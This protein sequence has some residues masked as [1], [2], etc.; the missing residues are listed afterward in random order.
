MKKLI[1][2]FLAAIMLVP[3][4]MAATLGEFPGFLATKTDTTSRANAYVIVGRSAAAS[5]V[6][7]G[8]DLAVRIAEM[9]YDVKQVP[10]GV[11]IGC[12]YGSC[13][14]AEVALNDGLLNDTMG[15]ELTTAIGLGPK[16]ITYGG[17]EYLVTEKVGVPAVSVNALGKDYN[18]TIVMQLADG[19]LYYEI[20]LPDINRTLYT[21]N[22]KNPLKVQI[23]GKLFQITGAEADKFT[24]LTGV[25]GD[26]DSV[27]PKCVVYGDYS[28]CV[29]DGNGAEGWAY[30]VVKDAAGN[31]IDSAWP[32]VG[33][34]VEFTLGGQTIKAKLI[35][36]R[37]SPT[38][39]VI[40]ATLVVGPE[41]DEVYEDGEPFPGSELWVFDITTTGDCLTSIKVEYKP[42]LSED[43]TAKYVTLGKKI[44]AP[45]D[46]FEFGLQD[47]LVKTYTK[48][49]FSAGTATIYEDETATKPLF[50]NKPAIIIEATD[51]VF[52]NQNAKKAYIAYN[53]SLYVIG[54][55]NEILGRII[56]TDMEADPADLDNIEGK[57]DTHEFV[58]D[59]QNVSSTFAGLVL[60]DGGHESIA[61]NYTFTSSAVILGASTSPEAGDV[62]EWDGTTGVGDYEGPDL[63]SSYGSVLKSNIKAN[64]GAQK[65]VVELPA[66]QQKAFVYMGKIG[67][68]V[69]TGGTYKEMVPI[70]TPVTRFADEITA[71]DKTST[72]AFVLVGGPCVNEL[73]A[74]LAADGKLKDSTGY[75]I[76]SCEAWPGRDFAL[77]QLIEDA[78][79]TTGK[80]VLVV[81]GT[82]AQDTLLAAQYLQA[83]KLEGST[84]KAVEVTGT[85]VA[86]ATATPI[87]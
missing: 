33:E 5:D 24:A 36:V 21:N 46:Y 29:P 63:T 4:A 84:A 51:Y 34:T 48:V 57:F 60:E 65:V 45:N 14:K 56:Q 87:A 44:V 50:S 30:L 1:A 47:L 35:A 17:K 74:E 11:A 15:N 42:S 54:Y 77:I 61:M 72:K 13:K 62:T 38:S 55:Y 6:L 27:T 80:V 3:V 8:I 32:N 18:G 16:K 58:I 28:F 75:T 66:E 10:G 43:E 31:E 12:E 85:T 25:M 83:G 49:T 22:Y 39:G 19:D 81:A 68:V 73:V 41:V 82:R 23:L 37:G 69:T 70:K 20:E 71:S 64:A 76:T 78:Y 2:T 7:G 86:T 40:Y 26:T 79:G 59:P 53:G 9:N 67:E 52:N